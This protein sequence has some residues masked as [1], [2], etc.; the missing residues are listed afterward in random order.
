[1]MIE[2]F[3]IMLGVALIIAALGM[4]IMMIVDAFKGKN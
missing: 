3:Q 4:A 2:A 1:M